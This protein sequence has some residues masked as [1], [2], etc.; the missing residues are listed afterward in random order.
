MS[1]ESGHRQISIYSSESA[2][3]QPLRLLRELFRDLAQGRQLGFAL[4]VRDLKAQY[5]QSLLGIVWAFGP[6]I[7]L[8]V[9]LTVAKS[10][11]LYNPGL[12]TL[13][14]PAYVLISTSLWQIF[15]A[16]LSGPMTALQ[17]N[18]GL[19]TKVRF[20]REAVIFADLYKICFTASIQ[21]VLIA[22]T[23]IWFHIPVKPSM[24][25]AP[26]ALLS[27]VVLGTSLGLFLAPLGTLYRD[28]ANSMQIITLVW[29]TITPVTYPYPKPGVM[30][31]VFATTVRLNPVTPLLVTVRE[32]AAGEPLTLLPQFF[33]VVGLALALLLLGLVVLRV[34]IPLLIERWSA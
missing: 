5:R 26:F 17:S 1:L 27:L 20:P 11:R 31:G 2:L 23:F 28:V 9:M 3:R 14:F 13:P 32:L 16:S 30:E 21:L 19:L 12:T 29:L 6:P 25:F 8:A 7:F 18:K 33:L 34:S 4:A 15:T 22:G 10:N 24:I